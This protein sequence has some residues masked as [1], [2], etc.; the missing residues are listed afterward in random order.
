MRLFPAWE[1]NFPGNYSIPAPFWPTVFL[2]GVLFTLL[3][4]Y[5]MIER[6]LTGDTVSHHLLQRPRDVPVRT[7]L[8][9]MSIAFYVVL[10]I[11]GG[12]DVIADKFDISLNAMTWIGRI[13]LVV[14]PPIV[15]FFTYRICLGLEQHDREVL[16]H[17]IETGVIRRLPHGEFIEVHQPLGPV[18][19]HGHGKLAYG[20]APV[21]KRMN[22]VGGA[23]RAIRGFFSP[24][25]SPTAVELEQ[26]AEGRGLASA[27]EE[28]GRE[29]TTSGRP[30]E[31]G[32]PSDGG[33]PQE[34][35]D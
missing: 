8:G 32:R 27:E 7:S 24:I 1:I 34:P 11:S 20:G 33:R 12:N 5:P 22:Q 28:T 29:L 14:V 19:A 10:V 31:G 6:K 35:R 25:E 16:E 17:G 23:R 18:D 30:S 4:L 15:Y 3:A 13:G 21:P 2:P 9:T 26:R